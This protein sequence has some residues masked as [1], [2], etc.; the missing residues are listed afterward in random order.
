MLKA[1]LLEEETSF[2]FSFEKQ[3]RNALKKQS[4]FRSFFPLHCDSLAIF[5]FYDCVRNR[6]DHSDALLQV[7][8]SPKIMIPMNHTLVLKENTS[9]LSSAEKNDVVR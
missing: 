4:H 8:E 5:N 2:L 6:R 1:E 9:Y 3:N 7:L